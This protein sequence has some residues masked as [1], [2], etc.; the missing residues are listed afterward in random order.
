M[1]SGCADRLLSHPVVFVPASEVAGKFTV[2]YA[3]TTKSCH[4]SRMS[5]DVWFR[6]EGI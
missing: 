4:I 6:P 2:I 5:V 3:R 1:L